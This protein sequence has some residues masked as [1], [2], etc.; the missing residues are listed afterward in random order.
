MIYSKLEYNLHDATIVACS[1]EKRDGVTME[2]QLYGITY[3]GSPFLKLTCSG[4]KNIVESIDFFGELNKSAYK[5]DW[6]GNRVETVAYSAAKLS[7][8]LDIHLDIE[9][10]GFDRFTVNCQKLHFSET[11]VPHHL[12]NE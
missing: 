4:I 3:S 2:F 1:I 12:I 10:D 8:N 6:N 9:I 7:K 11:Y 5:A